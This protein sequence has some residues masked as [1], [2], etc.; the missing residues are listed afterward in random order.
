[1]KKKWTVIA[2]NNFEY[3]KKIFKNYFPLVIQFKLFF[4]NK[5]FYASIFQSKSEKRK[6]NESFYR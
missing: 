6:I 3:Y 4:L 2:R 1:M 5:F